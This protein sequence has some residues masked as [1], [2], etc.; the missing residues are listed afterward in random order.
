MTDAKMY[1]H[2]CTMIREY[3]ESSDKNNANRVIE[4][5]DRWVSDWRPF[6]VSAAELLIEIRS[7]MDEEATPRARQNAIRRIIRSCPSNHPSMAG[8]FPYRDYFVVCDGYRL[9]RLAKDIPSLPHVENDFNVGGIM[10]DAT[11]SAEFLPLPTIGELRSYIAAHKVCR[12]RKTECEPYCLGAYVWCNP[13]YLLDM[14][15]ALPKCTACKP[16]SPI[17]PIYFVE[18]NGDDGILLPVRHYES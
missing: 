11:P 15:Q 7:R 8:I 2:I 18:P 17:S 16:K 1:E 13:K 14:L 9:I 10:L 6:Y 12:G 4:H 5:P 3:D